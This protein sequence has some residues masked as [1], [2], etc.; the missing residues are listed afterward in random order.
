MSKPEA[1]DAQHEGASNLRA[2]PMPP[3][4]A[5]LMPPRVVLGSMSG[6]IGSGAKFHA[7]VS[8]R[9]LRTSHERPA[10]DNDHA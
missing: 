7:K 3:G 10:Q 5:P 4:V 9:E 8:F 6:S 2:P 1:L